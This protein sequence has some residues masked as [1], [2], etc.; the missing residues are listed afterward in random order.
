MLASSLF[1][2]IYLNL[3]RVYLKT[4][5]YNLSS[6]E[7]NTRF[8]YYTNIRLL[9][10]A[11]KP[12]WHLPV[13]VSDRGRCRPTA[14]ELRTRAFLGSRPAEGVGPAGRSPRLRVSLKFTRVLHRKP[15]PGEWCAPSNP[16]SRPRNHAVD[17]A[18]AHNWSK[19][20]SVVLSRWG[21]PSSSPSDAADEAGRSPRRGARS[22]TRTCSCARPGD[23]GCRAEESLGFPTVTSSL[24]LKEPGPPMRKD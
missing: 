1:L 7:E 19:R 9:C 2:N 20:V 3:S 12:D 8:P 21:Q 6:L 4:W 13:W 15:Q 11:P 14:A 10:F 24:G 16:T 17:T 23:P 5:R 18:Q 22:P